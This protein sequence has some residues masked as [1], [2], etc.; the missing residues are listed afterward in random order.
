MSSP[1]VADVSKLP[2][3]EDDPNAVSTSFWFLLLAV[4][5]ISAIFALTY[6][7]HAFM[8]KARQGDKAPGANSAVEKLYVMQEKELGVTINA[9]KLYLTN[10]DVVEGI[11]VDTTDAEG[12]RHI[13]IRPV[14][15]RMQENA[16]TADP[17]TAG[18]PIA[19][20][21]PAEVQRV[22]RGRGKKLAVPIGEALK[23]YQR[24]LGK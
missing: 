18:K 24:D 19:E 23:L 3:S 1:A 6:L 14:R 7:A 9:D 8:E 11:V 4:F 16:N 12:V 5:M 10:G 17:A 13:L 21:T 2:G 15:Y 22:E 20:Y